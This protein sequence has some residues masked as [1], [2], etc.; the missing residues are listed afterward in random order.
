MTDFKFEVPVHHKS[1][2]K[3]IGVGGGGSNAVGYMYTQGIKDVDFVVCNTDHQALETNPVKEKL[4]I[5]SHLTEGLGAGARPEVGANAAEESKE[6]IRKLLSNDTKMLFITAGMGGGTGTGAAPVI[7]KIAKDLG[8]LTVGIVTMPFAFEGKRKKRYAEEGVSELKKNC[9]T[10]LVILNER[11][12]EV[13]GGLGISEAFSKADNVLTNAARSIAQVITHKAKMNVDFEDVKT[14]MKNSG[15][16]VMGSAVAK[17]ENRAKEAIENALNSPLLNNREVFGAQRILLSFTFSDDT[18]ELTIDELA[19]VTDYIDD[20]IG[21]ESDEVIWGQGVDSNLEDG[22]LRVTVI[23]TGF[24]EEVTV[25]REVVNLESTKTVDIHSNTVEPKEVIV[26]KSAP[27][28]PKERVEI[29]APAAPTQ[30]IERVSLDL[31]GDEVEPVQNDLTA[32]SLQE[33]IDHVKQHE[34]K[35]Q[36]IRDRIKRMAEVNRLK[37]NANS[38]D[39]YQAYFDKPAFARRNKDINASPSSEDSKLSR[40]NLND[41]DEI[42]GNNRFFDDNVD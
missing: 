10:V 32:Q 17:G 18:A 22:E 7:A 30:P 29:K 27:E 11:L 36:E 38:D 37:G 39:T 19:T 40:Y 4:Q 5:G 31:D 35:I 21:E 41:D 42:V 9:D 16:T 14:I 1:I 15:Q 2:I 24:E 25:S 13:Y 20:R 26:E 12:K 34:I 23:A 6:D 33:E 28:A 3:V 8:I